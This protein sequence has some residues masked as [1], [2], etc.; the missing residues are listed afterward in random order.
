MNYA[1]NYTIGN[2][3]CYNAALEGMFGSYLEWM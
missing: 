3:A 1:K 2:P